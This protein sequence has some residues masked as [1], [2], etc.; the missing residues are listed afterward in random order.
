MIYST[1]SEHRFGLIPANSFEIEGD[2]GCVLC[3]Y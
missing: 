2:K 1:T 3:F